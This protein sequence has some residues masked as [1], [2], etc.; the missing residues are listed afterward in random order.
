MSRVYPAETSSGVVTSFIPLTTVFTPPVE[1]AS[2]FRLDGP[3]LVAFDPGYGLDIDTDV[4]CAPS[5]VTTWWE[6]GRFGGGSDTD[7][8]AV[9]LGPL[10]CPD[11]WTTLASSTK[12]DTSTLALCCPSGYYLENGIPGSVKGDCLSDISSGAILTFASTSGDDSSLWSTATTTL[13]A[14]SYVGAIAVVGWNIGTT[15]STISAASQSSTVSPSSSTISS[16]TESLA[17]PGPVS[18]SQPSSNLAPIIQES[19][20]LSARA[21]TGVGVGVGLGVAVVIIGL[22]AFTIYVKRIRG[23]E[24]RSAEDGTDPPVQQPQNELP[25]ELHPEG[26]KHELDGNRPPAELQ[27]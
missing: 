9:S 10:T 27:G 4:R 26:V 7:H 15:G 18:T 1:C 20:S 25:L 13:S 19:T 3:S 12:D 17:T 16:P 5:A 23:R 21:A 6:Q 14:N 8:T 22:V 24:R 2:H 11:K